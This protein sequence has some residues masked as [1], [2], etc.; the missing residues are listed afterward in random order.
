MKLRLLPLMWMG[1]APEVAS[2]LTST[3]V[4]ELPDPTR[5]RIKQVVCNDELFGDHAD[6]GDWLLQSANL[7]AYIRTERSALSKPGRAG[8]T[9]I[10]IVSGVTSVDIEEAVPLVPLSDGTL[11]WFVDLDFTPIEDGRGAGLRVDG[12]LADGTEAS[13]T[14]WLDHAGERLEVEGADAFDVVPLANSVVRGNILSYNGYLVG[15]GTVTDD[16]GGWFRWEDTTFLQPAT[17]AWLS[18]ILPERFIQPVLGWCLDGEVVFLR[19]AEGS[20]VQRLDITATDGDFDFLADK[21]A[22]EIVCAASA[23][24]SSGWQPLPDWEPGTPATE[25]LQLEVGDFGTLSV[26]VTDPAGAPVPAT[27]WWND[28]RYFLG[29]GEGTLGVGAGPGAGLV[30][31]GPAWTA[32][33]LP[34]VEVGGETA[35][36]AVLRRVLPDDVVLADFF[37]ESWPHSGSRS[38]ASSRVSRQI[39]AGAE[40]AITVGDDVV[41]PTDV[42]TLERDE[43]WTFT[44][45]R[46]PGAFGTITSW[47]WSFNR[48]ANLW[49]AP[50]TTGLDPHE[51]LAVMGGGRGLRTIVDLTWVEQAG[52]PFSWPVTP[53]AVYLSGLDDLPAYVDLLDAWVG[54]AAVGPRTWIDGVDR[55]TMPFVEADRALSYRRTMATTGPLVQLSLVAPAPDAPPRGGR[56]VQVRV[57]A[58]DWMPVD[59]AALIGPEG[60]VLAEWNL[61]S[62]LNAERLDVE[63]D[64]PPDTTWVLATAWSDRTAPP[65]QDSPPWTITSGLFVER[66]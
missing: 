37:I 1:C 61:G 7:T 45:A 66:P 65:L 56:S 6:R 16:R 64:L 10:D 48:R 63:V 2:E 49:G 28:S 19:D 29:L 17:D 62:P 21:D 5:S 26:K 35:T 31:A 55:R 32:S 20:V 22:T 30:G 53:D 52:P 25:E 58:P 60:E 36:T 39:A 27:V 46:A 57:T 23:R 11:D 38:S 18:T 59:H 33:S 51:A 15:P 41:A 8:G 44:G 4:P 9:L 54:L 47:P 43:V 14:W 34:T 42:S 3:C 24:E 40:W 50:D 12:V 13:V